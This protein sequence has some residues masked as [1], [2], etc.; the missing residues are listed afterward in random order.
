MSN[1]DRRMRITEIDP[2][3]SEGRPIPEQHVE[4]RSLYDMSAVVAESKNA[5]GALRNHQGYLPSED[6]INPH[7][8]VFNRAS[9]V[10]ETVRLA[11]YGWKEG[12]DRLSEY[13]AALDREF[14]KHI[15]ANRFVQDL[16]GFEVDVPAFLTGQP[17]HMMQFEQGQTR[18][19][20]INVV[21]DINVRCSACGRRQ[22]DAEPTDPKW[23]MVRGAAVTMLMKVLIRAGYKP[24]LTARTSTTYN[25]NQRD[26]PGTKHGFLRTVDVIIHSPSDVFDMDRVNFA[27]SHESMIRRLEW[28]IHE[29]LNTQMYGPPPTR[30]LSRNSM[31]P[32]G[33]VLLHE[34]FKPASL[35]SR[36][37][38]D[39]YVPS[40]PQ[41]EDMSAA[42]SGVLADS[43]IGH[44]RSSK[45]SFDDTKAA[46]G[47]VF[48]TLSAQGVKF[49]E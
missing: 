39:V 6:T 34:S 3:P 19:K 37:V 4:F 1:Y 26:W 48:S 30:S 40:I 8:K 13:Q 21:V 16:S 14:R 10:G 7:E 28:R 46:I 18:A 29:I 41:I 11:Q 2:A 44:T 9:T 22:H 20:S 49:A 32:V 36:G 24:T 5:G 45:D 25:P 43:P 15:R 31:Q 38:G 12:R 23:V 17:E 47:W 35:S 33:L 42:P 27:L